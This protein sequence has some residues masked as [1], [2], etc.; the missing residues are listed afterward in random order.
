M[1]PGVS[2]PST[3]KGDDYNTISGTSMATPHVSGAVALMLATAV[4]SN[5]ADGDGSWDPAEVRSVL[6]DTADWPWTGGSASTYGYGL[7]DAEE[8]ATGTQS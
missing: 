2:I 3:W 7:L 8:A 6:H 4:G 5:D 1:A